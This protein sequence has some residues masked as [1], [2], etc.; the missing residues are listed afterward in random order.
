VP[1]PR[2]RPDTASSDATLNEFRALRA[3]K[4]KQNGKTEIGKML[5]YRAAAAALT[6]A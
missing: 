5:E 3:A 4:S 6:F 2:S 1:E